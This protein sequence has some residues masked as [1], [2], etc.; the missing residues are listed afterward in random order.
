MARSTSG[1]GHETFNLVGRLLPQGFE[2]PTRYTCPRVRLLEIVVNKGTLQC[3]TASD[4]ARNLVVCV[5]SHAL[6]YK[7]LGK[8]WEKSP[9]RTLSSAG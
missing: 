8:L 6:R 1:L 9:K 4:S 7:L 5:L 2:S 3:H